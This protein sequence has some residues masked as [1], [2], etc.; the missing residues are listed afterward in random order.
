MT[1]PETL[2][3]PELDRL[4]QHLDFLFEMSCSPGQSLLLVMSEALSFH[5]SQ[6]FGRG[7][8]V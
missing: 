3:A 5:Y 1:L 7:H 2:R 4:A 6:G 8:R